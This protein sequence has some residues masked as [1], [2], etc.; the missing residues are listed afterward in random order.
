M[1]EFRFAPAA[2]PLRGSFRVPADKSISH[3]AAILA[4]L[5]DGT[6]RIENFLESETTNATLRCLADLGAEIQRTS[7]DTL[8]VHGHGLG[9][10]REPG[11]VLF[12][13]GSGTTMRLLAGV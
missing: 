10:L 4:A 7:P 6:T 2:Q 5:A 3:R 13:A 1:S 9:S 12:C 11:Q 8:T